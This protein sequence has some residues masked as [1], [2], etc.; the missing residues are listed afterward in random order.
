[1]LK[2]LVELVLFSRCW[3]FSVCGVGS[4][5]ILCGCSVIGVELLVCRCFREIG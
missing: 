1:M 4:L 3:F 5:V 2:L